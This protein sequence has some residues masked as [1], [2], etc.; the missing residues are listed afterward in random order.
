MTIKDVEVQ[1]EIGA[2]VH[3]MLPPKDAE[4]EMRRDSLQHFV[5]YNIRQLSAEVSTFVTN[6]LEAINS[7]RK[8]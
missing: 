2:K 7:V 8:D 3:W 6:L 5:D 1:I 4:E